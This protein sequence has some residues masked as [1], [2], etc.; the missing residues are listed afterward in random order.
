MLF[1]NM[2]KEITNLEINLIFQIIFP[3]A[4]IIDYIRDTACNSIEIFYMQSNHREILK[5]DFLPDDIYIYSDNEKMS[6]GEPMQDCELL[7][8][9][10]QFTMAK[11]YS[12]MWADNPFII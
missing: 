8:K 9:Y 6:D 4:K 12:E 1:K 3:C 5:A 10:R 7:Y 2:A 11:G